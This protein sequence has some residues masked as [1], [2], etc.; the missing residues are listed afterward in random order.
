MG[1]T[2]LCYVAQMSS[3]FEDLTD[4]EGAEVDVYDGE[5]H[6]F[7]LN[8]INDI[9]EDDGAPDRVKMR[10]I[11]NADGS[12]E[13]FEMFMCS[14]IEGTLVQ[15]E[16]AKQ[17]IDGTSITMKQLGQRVEEDGLS[18]HYVDMSGSLNS[19]SAYTSK[20][21]TVKGLRANG[22]NW[23][24]ATISQSPAAFNLSGYRTGS[25]VDDE[26]CPAGGEYAEAAYSIGQMLGD[27]SATLTDIAMGDGAS[28]FSHLGSCGDEEPHSDSGN[29]AWNGDT[30]FPVD[31][32]EYLA[33]AIAGSLPTIESEAIS[34]S[35]AADETWDC[36]DD[37]GVGIVDFPESPQSEM[38]APCSSYRLGYEEIHCWE[39]INP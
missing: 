21:I 16:Y 4:S 8:L 27:T 37:I 28:Q 22:S 1:D 17:V 15:N 20:E 14:L 34:I 5:W 12:I 3:T 18:L 10:V 25:F 13:S 38:E 29:E 26:F 9:G 2:I 6:I 30:G 11:K 33:D 7:N 35:F 32:N 36:T 23:E 19:D 31:S 39:V 24:E